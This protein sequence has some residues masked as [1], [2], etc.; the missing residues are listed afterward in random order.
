MDVKG[1]KVT[2]VGLG[3][4]GR[5]ATRLL[6]REG[7]AVTVTDRRTLAE[8]EEPMAALHDCPVRYCA[9][10]HP[11]EAF[12]GAEWIVMSPGITVGSVDAVQA[13]KDRGVP[14]IGELELASRFITAPVAAITGT[15][16]KSTTTALIGEILKQTGRR[17]FVGGN[18]GRPLCEAVLEPGE[19]DWIVAE[20]SSFQLETI[21]TFRPRVAVLLNVT[22][23]HQDRY[24]TMEDY[25]AAKMRLFENQTAEDAAVINADDP[26]VLGH[27]DRIRARRIFFSRTPRPEAGLPAGQAGVYLEAGAVISYGLPVRSAR[28]EIIRR[29]EIPLPGSHNLENVLAASAAGLLC[30]CPADPIRKAIREFKGLAHRLEPVRKRNGVLYVNDSKAT[31]VVALAKALEAFSEPIVLIAGGRNK[32]AEFNLLRDLVRR[33]VKT[34]VLIGEARPILRAAW[35]GAA[36]LIEAESLEEAVRVAAQTA[37]AGDVVLLAPACASFDMFRDFED[38][39]NRFKEIV[40]GL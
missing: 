24:R 8:L 19:W 28:V 40:N 26:L 22:P 20:V 2:V 17:V 30:G 16:G 21:Q 35:N 15:N 39:G 33:R 5:A 14:V 23:N 3:R 4:S 1:K 7:A 36:P 38:R 12:E 29:E 27:A 34:A 37:A 9:G 31:T 13:A 6:V 18:L 10:G 11:T 32:G 25:R